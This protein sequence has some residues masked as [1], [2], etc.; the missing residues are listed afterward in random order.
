MVT[1]FILKGEKVSKV[2]RTDLKYWIVQKSFILT[3]LTAI[4]NC[5]QM[6]TVYCYSSPK[7]SI[8]VTNY[9]VQDT[10]NYQS[11]LSC[12]II[13]LICDFVTCIAILIRL[14]GFPYI[15]HAPMDPLTRDS[16]VVV[17]KIWGLKRSSP[18]LL[19][20]KHIL[21]VSHYSCSK[22]VH[23]LFKKTL[24]FW[25]MHVF[26]QSTDHAQSICQ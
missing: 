18:F 6:Q 14:W 22:M 21:D 23:N 1:Y 5:D 26:F 24:K 10:W 20:V 9:H 7:Q 16:R 15:S 11:C 8:S 19:L 2:G 4:D 13:L 12:L 25:C 17:W 3:G